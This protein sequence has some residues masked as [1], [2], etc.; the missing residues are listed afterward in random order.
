MASVAL[1]CECP[2]HITDLLVR[3]GNFE[4]YSAEC[5]SRSPAD[6]VLH[7]YLKEVTGNAR[8]LLEEALAHVVAAEGI[9]MP[10]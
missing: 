4:T 9:S 1:N 3:L 5:E 6:A 8:A 2:R 7:H 10:A